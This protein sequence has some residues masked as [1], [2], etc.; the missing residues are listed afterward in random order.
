MVYSILLKL[1]ETYAIS[2]D[3]QEELLTT[4]QLQRRTDP[5]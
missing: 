1:S 3:E 5:P 2:G 4:L